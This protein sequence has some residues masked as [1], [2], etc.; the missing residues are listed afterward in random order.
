M[1][2][3]GSN[4]WIHVPSVNTNSKVPDQWNNV[5][6]P[7]LTSRLGIASFE[8]RQC[9]Q[10]LAADTQSIQRARIFQHH[11][12][13]RLWE[14]GVE[15]RSFI[16]RAMEVYETNRSNRRR[17]LASAENDESF[18]T[19]AV[20]KVHDQ[21]EVLSTEG[22]NTFV[23]RI[24]ATCPDMRNSV[25]AQTTIQ[26]I[27]SDIASLHQNHEDECDGLTND[28]ER[29]IVAVAIICHRILQ[30][31]MSVPAPDLDALVSRPWLRH[32]SIDSILVYI[33]WDSIPLLERNGL[34]CLA[35]SF[36]T[37]TLLGS[38]HNDTDLHID[39]VIE[40]VN[41]HHNVSPSVQ[42]LLPR[43]NR[44]KAF[45]RLVIDLN[46]VERARKKKEIEQS[47]TKNAR[48]T[49][50]DD[51]ATI[52][53]QTPIQRLCKSIIYNTSM[54]DSIPFSSIRNLARRLK[55]PLH[56]TLKDSINRES[57][58]LGI[59]LDNDDA[60]NETRPDR[61]SDWTPTTD[62]TVANAVSN[63]DKSTL[64]KRCSFVGWENEN[65]GQD[66][67]QSAQGLTVEELA[68][69][70]YNQGR[71]PEDE[72]LDN[73]LKGGYV[74]WHCEGSHI[75][76]IFRILCLNDL[77]CHDF[78]AE[79]NIFITPYQTSPYDLHVGM[80][81]MHIFNT[82]DE[83]SLVPARSFY[84]RR[85]VVIDAFLDRLSGLDPQSICNGLH[86]A[87]QK[88]WQH[89]DNMAEI[90]KDESLQRDAKQ[91]RSLSCIAAGLGGE[92]LARIF[93]PMCFDYRHFCGG[94]PDL[95]L[96]RA[97]YSNND[98]SLVD[99]GDWIGEAF[100]DEHIEKGKIKQGENMLR[101]DEFLG[102]T[103]NG[104]ALGSSQKNIS[105]TTPIEPITILP[106]RLSLEHNG[107][108]VK[109]DTVLVEVKSANDRL[110]ARQEDWLNILDESGRV[111]KFENKKEGKKRSSNDG[112]IL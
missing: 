64:G 77:L 46:H 82:E 62:F 96:V 14:I 50:S 12:S 59:R 65:N 81:R 10:K 63:G 90:L 85:R 95:L 30:D 75:R 57:S 56:D 34:Y 16:D 79:E 15:L 104:D 19:D 22:R 43:R 98:T 17:R 89:K 45:D 78:A 88:R 20:L 26:R 87:V 67:I 112:V 24:L 109:V 49:K 41:S 11:F 44:G 66:I 55:V 108:E 25:C 13:F 101:D 68:L 32:F 38:T 73:G 35:I 93:R 91:L 33:L 71:L 97:R 23:N 1:R 53:D 48:K 40:L 51:F 3:D 111:C 4:G 72:S 39:K 27:E 86:D 5:V 9:Y 84:E 18:T 102:C 29:M 92:V 105:K 76:A 47:S 94:L 36:L 21:F 106:P 6:Y 42:L 28:T 58:L 8:L 70:E 110:D 61:Y 2:G 69:E 31:R 99:L 74:G 100:S 103:K 54:T 52:K 7:G 83:S 37:T 107:K 60:R 80:Q